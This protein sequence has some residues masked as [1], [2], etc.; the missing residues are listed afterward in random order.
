M[1]KQIAL[2][3]Y[4]QNVWNSTPLNR[5]A[6]QR[7]LI[8]DL[9][10]DV[11][12]FQECGPKTIRA[13]AEALPPMLAE[14]YEEVPTEVG[15]Q[16]YTPVFYKR[17]RFDLIDHGYI[18]YKGKND[19]NSKS[20]TW[21]ILAEKAS[22]VRFGVCSTHF[23]WRCNEPDDNAHRLSNAA[24]L[25]ACAMDMKQRFD[26]PVIIG[27]DLNCGK[28]ASQGEEPWLWLCDRLI[29]VRAAAPITTEMLTHHAYPVKDENG[30]FCDAEMPKRTLDHM[31]VTEHPNIALRSFEVDT[32]RRALATSDHCPLILKATVLGE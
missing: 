26:V 11:C 31:F 29:D 21:A 18:L 2:S 5:T 4:C 20:V 15:E 13:D 32:S 8:F 9:D 10:A 19:A 25:Y 27:G 16:N 28:L 30:L 17:E 14:R 6:L 7:D 1:K 22:G 24:E 3:V 12:L 23:W